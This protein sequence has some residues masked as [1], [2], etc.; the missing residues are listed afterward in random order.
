MSDFHFCTGVS[1]KLS[2]VRFKNDSKAASEV[3]L[4]KD[5]QHLYLLHINILKNVYLKVSSH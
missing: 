4:D 3:K 1:K 5:Q 2:N